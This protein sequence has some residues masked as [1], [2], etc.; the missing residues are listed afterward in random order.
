MRC[1]VSGIGIAADGLPGWERSRALLA[2]HGCDP[3]YRAAV[4]DWQ[5]D[6]LPGSV[7]R[8]TTPVIRLALQVAAEATSGC[9]LALNDLPSVFASADGDGY[10]TDR[11]CRSMHLE[12]HPVSP[13]DFHNSVHN[14][15]AAYWS[16]CT[17]STAAS[18]SVSAGGATFSAGL[19]EAMTYLASEPVPAVLLVAYDLPLPVPLSDGKTAQ[20]PFGVALLLSRERLTGSLASLDI[21]TIAGET[22]ETVCEAALESLRLSNQAG[23]VL[24]L[25]C[26][27]ATGDAGDVVLHYSPDMA[28]R[29][30]VAPC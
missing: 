16:L 14:A 25:L 21:E 15:P 17:G 24:P 8:R 3:A 2:E 26:R 7:R 5:P 23:R 1:Y 12:G 4:E 29:V 9:E 30:E 13:T 19:L 11:I 27:L 6:I 20:Q 28:L 22:E 10:V 18:T